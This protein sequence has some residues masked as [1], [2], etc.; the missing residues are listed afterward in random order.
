MY[1]TVYH[2]TESNCSKILFQKFSSQLCLILVG[3]NI[4]FL[5][6]GQNIVFLLVG[7]NIVFRVL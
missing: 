4:V 6:V 7:Q 2:V 5:L 1:N 3:Q